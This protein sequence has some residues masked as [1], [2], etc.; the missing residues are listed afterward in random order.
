M[1]AHLYSFIA[2]GSDHELFIASYLHGHFDVAVANVEKLIERGEA[3]PI[4]TLQATLDAQLQK[5]FDD[6]ELSTEDAGQV[7]ALFNFLFIL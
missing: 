6:N 3:S 2:D 4:L 1:E 5:A 7:T